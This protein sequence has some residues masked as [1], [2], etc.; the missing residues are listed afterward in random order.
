MLMD[1]T[2]LNIT[3]IT[4]PITYPVLLSF[5]LVAVGNKNNE[6]ERINNEH[7]R[8]IENLEKEVSELKKTHKK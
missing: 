2:Q 7:K 3:V 1:L 5:V 8:R 6:H 4:M